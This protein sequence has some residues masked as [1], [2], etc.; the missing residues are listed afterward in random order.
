MLLV[1]MPS[2]S[3]WKDRVLFVVAIFILLTAM[4]WLHVRFIPN[5]SVRMGVAR[6]TLAERIWPSFLSLVYRGERFTCCGTNFYWLTRVHPNCAN[7]VQVM[8]G[9]MKENHITADKHLYSERRE[10]SRWSPIA[11]CP[12]TE[13]GLF[14]LRSRNII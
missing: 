2:I 14:I 11:H 7:T 1:V 3:A 13:S 10:M 6:P 9:M 12:K 8:V 5:A 4:L